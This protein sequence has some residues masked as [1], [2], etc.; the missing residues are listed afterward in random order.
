MEAPF[1]QLRL[2]KLFRGLR[3]METSFIVKRRLCVGEVFGGTLRVLRCR[4]PEFTSRDTA[5]LDHWHRRLLWEISEQ[6]IEPRRP[7]INPR[8]VKH[9]VSNY[10]KKHPHHRLLSARK[11]FL[12]TVVMLI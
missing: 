5:A 12:Q 6:T 4:L 11:P 8:V 2:E 3:A 1:F 7:R 9:Q 10:A